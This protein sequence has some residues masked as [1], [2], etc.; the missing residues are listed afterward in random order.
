MGSRFTASMALCLAAFI[1]TV[2]T[3]G[4]AVSAQSR[5]ERLTLR[6]ATVHGVDTPIHVIAAGPI[7]G[8]GTAE[9][10]ERSGVLTINLHA[11]SV[12][13]TNKTTS[14]RA[15]LDTRRCSAT[16]TEKGTFRIVG[17]TRGYRHT[18]GGG[19]YVTVRKLIGA[20][21]ASGACE[22]RSA[23]PR[24]VYVRTVLTGSAA[25]PAS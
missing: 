9:D 6:G 18:T 19:T 13:V 14:L 23:P 21:S 4:A 1:L 16:I 22:G 2:A 20:R 10:N 17:G 3:A 8:R 15:R 12:F 5:P 24:A 25:V 7:H 11:G